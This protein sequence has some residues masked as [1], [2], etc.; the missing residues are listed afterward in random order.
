[1]AA[2]VTAAG[3]P[4]AKVSVTHLHREECLGKRGSPSCQCFSS[5][6]TLLCTFRG[7]S[8]SFQ[9]DLTE[10]RGELSGHLSCAGSLG[11]NGDG[12]EGLRF[13]M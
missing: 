9:L 5:P 6:F 13:R 2:F 12:L 7:A 10:W 1:M 11:S 3:G 4:D 8:V